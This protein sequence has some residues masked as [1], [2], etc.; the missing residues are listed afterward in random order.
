M[1]ITWPDHAIENQWLQV[2]VKATDNTGL[3]EDD[4]FYFGNAPGEAGDSLNN[5][6]VNATDEIVARNFQHSAVDPAAIDDPYDYNRDG[7]VNGTDQIIA[8]AN[9]TNPLTM[10]RL[11]TAPAVDLVLGEMGGQEK[12][13][14]GLFGA[15]LD[16]A[17]ELERMIPGRQTGEK[18]P[19]VA[20]KNLVWYAGFLP[21]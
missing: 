21:D 10:L 3:L 13:G 4:V 19:S 14:S 8:R 18:Q 9:Q 12:H 15:E 1:T 2:T 20:S 5:A 11:I 7:L 16:W 6:I 17:H